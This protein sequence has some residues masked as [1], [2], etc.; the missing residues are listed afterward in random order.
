MLSQ[1]PLGRRRHTPEDGTAGVT[2]CLW[3]RLFHHW[4]PLL[5]LSQTASSWTPDH[6]LSR[7]SAHAM[8]YFQIIVVW[9]IGGQICGLHLWNKFW[10]FFDS[11]ADKP[12]KWLKCQN[13]SQMCHITFLQDACVDSFSQL[14]ALSFLI[15]YQWQKN[16][17]EE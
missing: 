5:P 17:A 4:P 13:I 10:N 8:F 11:Q 2:V 12:L 6:L 15:S 3:P 9:I 7:R 16:T 14:I 1:A